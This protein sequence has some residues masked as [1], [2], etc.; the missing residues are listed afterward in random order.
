LI[1][2]DAA[3]LIRPLIDKD[4]SSL[5]QL[6][7]FLEATYG[8]PNRK[9]SSQTKLANLKQG[10]RGFLAHFA[11][12]RRLAVDAGLNEDAQILQLR[13]SLN[14]EL[15]RSMIGCKIPGTL[16][17]YANLIAAYDNDL[18]F[19]RTRVE[20]RRRPSARDPNAMDIDTLDYAPLGSEERERRRR[21][22]LCFKCG[23]AHHISPNCKKPIPK[24]S[25][26]QERT[27][28]V[29]AITYPFART[30]PHSPATVSSASSSNS[31]QSKGKSRA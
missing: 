5:S 17:D 23:S 18:N 7:S 2:G 8:D 19:L 13:M 25:S 16:T 24:R 9:V 15:Q 21:K 22:G 31:R 11:E 20:N 10:Q 12:F 4:I 27:K 6:T 28:N 3:E 1:E 30:R 14:S 26:S 29:N